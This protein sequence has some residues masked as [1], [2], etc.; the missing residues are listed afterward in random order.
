[1]NITSIVGN[2]CS[3]IELKFISE[4]FSVA[5]F[6]VAVKNNYKDKEGNYGST[7][8]PCKAINKQ[9]ELIAE[10]FQKGDCIALQMFYAPETFNNKEGNKVTKPMFKITGLTFLNRRREDK[11]NEEDLGTPVDYGDMPF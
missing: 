8:F 11:P 9:A 3:D 7:F 5:S 6:S 1:M 10:K 2:I 4:N